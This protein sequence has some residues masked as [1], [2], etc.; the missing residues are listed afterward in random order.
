[1]I[2]FIPNI[3]TKTMEQTLNIKTKKLQFGIGNEVSGWFKT[4][5]GEKT[6]FKIYND[7]EVEQSGEKDLHPFILGLYEMLFSVE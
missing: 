6:S 5:D 3:K 2:I 7:G 4:T 1:M